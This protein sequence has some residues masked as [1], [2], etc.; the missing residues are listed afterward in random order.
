MRKNELFQN[1]G[2]KNKLH[3]KFKDENNSVT[4][5]IKKDCYFGF[6]FLEVYLA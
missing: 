4:K 6:K 1:L 3:A 5:K 2:T